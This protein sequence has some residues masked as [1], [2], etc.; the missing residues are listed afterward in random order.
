MH[1]GGIGNPVDGGNQPIKLGITIETQRQRRQR[2]SRSHRVSR[3][4]G[5]DQPLPHT[6]GSRIGNPAG[7]GNQPIKLGITIET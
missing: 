3:D 2:V 6:N 4:I 5:N 1:G 7:G